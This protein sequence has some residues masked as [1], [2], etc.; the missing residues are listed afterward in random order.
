[1]SADRNLELHYAHIHHRLSESEIV[2]LHSDCLNGE[3]GHCD[4]KGR[5][6]CTCTCG[7]EHDEDCD[8]CDGT[9]RCSWLDAEM[10][11]RVADAKEQWARLKSETGHE[12]TRHG[13]TTAFTQM[14]GRPPAE[15]E[16]EEFQKTIATLRASAGVREEHA[17]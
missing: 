11:G 9:G 7:H 3:C 2:S 8:H 17:R 1:M 15:S 12:L 10:L 4:G 16:L 5:I 13:F 14:F 6:D